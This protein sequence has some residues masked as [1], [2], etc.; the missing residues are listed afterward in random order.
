MKVK[1]LLFCASFVVLSA[2]ACRDEC[3]RHGG[4]AGREG[5][6]RDNLYVLRSAIDKFHEDQHRYPTDLQELVPGY[7]RRIPKDPLTNGE[8]VVIR[9]PSGAID[10]VTSAKGRTCDGIAYDEL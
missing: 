7:L 9:D 4:R 3:N 5:A 6:A 1:Q 2:T 8:W 10:V